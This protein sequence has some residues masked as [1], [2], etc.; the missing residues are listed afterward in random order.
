MAR[1]I[2]RVAQDVLRKFKRNRQSDKGSWCV[3][4]DLQTIIKATKVSNK[5]WLHFKNGENFKK[6]K[7]AKT[8]QRR[9][10]ARQNIKFLTTSI[11]I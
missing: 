9:W 6:Y 5:H 2:K 8:K 3:N 10:L 4:E 11:V 7:I 1:Q